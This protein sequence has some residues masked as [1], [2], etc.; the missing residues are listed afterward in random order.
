VDDDLARMLDAHVA[1]EAGRWHGENL[2]ATVAEAV[3][4]GFEHLDGVP[5]R[6]L[7]P[8]ERVGA[9]LRHLVST[10]P[11]TDELLAE[12]EWALRAAHESLVDETV[13][14]A[15]VLTEPA[16]RQVVDAVATQQAIRGELVAQVTSSAVYAQLISHVLYHGLKNYLLTENAVVRTLPG[17]SSLL[18]MG[19]NAMRSANPNMEAG[20]DR[21]L[22]AFVTS[23]VAETVLDSH[24]FLETVLDEAVVGTV[25]DEV[26]TTNGPR[27]VGEFAALVDDTGLAGMV[28]TGRE[29]W[30]AVRSSPVVGRVVDAVVEQFYRAHGDEPVTVLLVDLGVTPERAAAALVEVVTPGLTV[31]AGNGGMLEAYV[32][33]RLEA[34]YLTWSPA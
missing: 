12:V 18:R 30:T 13:P 17:A 28:A 16:Y 29:V 3:D 15:D 2:A 4:A 27:P 1:F 34:F 25:A 11:L 24:E 31:A 23:N 9:W 8:P 32:R 22:I 19:Q 5:L 21:R 26:W 6:D 14:L 20:I 10:E 7:L 33:Q